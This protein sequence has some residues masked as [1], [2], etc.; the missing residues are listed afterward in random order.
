[1]CQSLVFGLDERTAEEI[2]KRRRGETKEKEPKGSVKRAPTRRY[3]SMEKKELKKR[4]WK[5]YRV[6]LSKKEGKR[7][8]E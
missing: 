5:N 4:R 7:G 3:S 8:D 2:G 1:M 6:I